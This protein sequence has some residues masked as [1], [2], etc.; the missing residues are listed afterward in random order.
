MQFLGKS[1]VITGAA[2]GIGE[3]V[4]IAFAEQGAKLMLADI[5]AVGLQALAQR[6]GETGAEVAC[7]VLDV[8]QS[9]QMHSLMLATV[10][11]YGQIDIF[12]NNAG[13][14]CSNAFTADI[15]EDEFDRVIAVNLKAVWLGMKYAILQMQKQG[16]GVII[17]T[18][19]ALG[20]TVQAAS[21]S[22]NS[23]KHAVAGLTRSAA[24]EYASQNIRIN[25]ICPGVIRTAMLASA[26]SLETLEPALIA[27]HPVGR[28]GEPQEV[29]DAVLWLASDKAS[30]VHGT[31]LSVDGGWTA[32]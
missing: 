23:A 21:A 32:S 22:Y 25:A 20:I 3:A 7:F 2:S 1:V 28:L 16:A 8:T 12:H 5:N 30:F 26:P 6:L 27:L 14:S 15:T 11:R 29:A 18:A 19:S 4:A 31:L 24:V 17:N 9:A 10:E 13:I